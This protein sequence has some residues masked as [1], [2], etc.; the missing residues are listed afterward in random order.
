MRNHC[1]EYPIENSQEIEAPARAVY[2]PS[3]AV[4]VQPREIACVVDVGV[5]E[6]DRVEAGELDRRRRPVSLAQ[7]FHAL[8]QSAVDEH[9]GGLSLNEVLRTGNRAR[10][11]EK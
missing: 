2:R 11:A 9:S 8:E 5:R 4:L 3:V 1:K 7:S 6:Y 10:R